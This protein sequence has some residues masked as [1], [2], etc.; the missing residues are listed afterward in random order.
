MTKN[1]ESKYHAEMLENLYT[2]VKDD[3]EIPLWLLYALNDGLMGLNIVEAKAHIKEFFMEVLSKKHSDSLQR[4]MDLWVIQ[5]MDKW[6]AEEVQLERETFDD[7]K[8]K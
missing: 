5:D 6:I 3:N 8:C 7:V 1:Y 4:C 2:I